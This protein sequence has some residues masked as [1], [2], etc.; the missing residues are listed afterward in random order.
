MRGFVLAAAMAV[1]L[2]SAGAARAQ[3]DVVAERRA[4]LD[5]VE[6]HF[7]AVAATVQQR[8]DQR[9]TAGK[10]E[11]MIAFFRTLP[12]RFPAATLT[13]PLPGGREAGQTRARETIEATRPDFNQRSADMVANLVALRA[14]AE[15]GTISGDMLRGTANTC[16][17]CHRGYRA[18]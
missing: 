8:G 2:G 10:V 11:E 7:E 4:G 15:A 13:P 12:D 6:R 17:A 18:R 9:A 5:R 3:G 1:G 14:A 16:I